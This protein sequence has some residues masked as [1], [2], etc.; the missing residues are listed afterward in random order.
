VGK[1]EHINYPIPPKTHASMYLMHKFWARKP[2]N[3][4]NEYIKI[5]SN[6]GD[7]VLDP[8]CGSGVTAIE[9]VKLERRVVA[10]DIDPLATFITRMTGI[11]IDIEKLKIEF[12]KIENNIKVKI[13]ELYITKCKKCGKKENIIEAIIWNSNK[14]LEIRYSCSCSKSTLWKEP[15]KYDID[16]INRINKIEIPFWYPQN[17]LIWNPRVNVNKGMTVYDLFTHRNLYALSWILNEIENIN[18]KNIKEILKFAFSAS[19]PQ[20]SKLV[21][22]I[23]SK[24]REK[25]VG[26]WSIRGYWIPEEHFEINVWN[27]F[28]E[29]IKKLIRGK[30][31]SN[32]LLENLWF[33]AKIFE[34]LLKDK[35][36]LIQT[37]SARNLEDI[38]D[39]SIDYI[40]TDPPYGDSVPYLELN[41]L[42]SSWL[43]FEPNFEEEIIISDS[44]VRKK[45]S[46]ELYSS[47]LRNSFDVMFRVLK[48]N[49]YL[50]VT[51]HNTDI[52]I[53]NALILAVK[54]AGFE[55][56]KIVYQLPPRSSPKALTAPFG[57]ADG[58]YYIRFY[59]AKVKNKIIYKDIID[60][61]RFENIV[62]QSLIEIIA[63]RMEPVIFTEIL[64][65][66]YIKLDKY[67][68]LPA[69]K[70][71]KLEEIIKKHK[72]KEFI[73]IKN[74]GWW[75]KDPEKYYL[76]ITPL[77]ERIETLIIQLLKR[78]PKIDFDE[79][80]KEIFTKLPNGLS[81]TE[82]K[83]KDI[84]EEYA[85]QS[86]DKSWIRKQSF[87][88]RI[89]EH[90]EMIGY[91]SII[92]KKLGFKILIG[93]RE[94]SS[95]FNDKSL[96]ELNDDVPINIL[97]DIINEIL[98]IDVLWIDDSKIKYSFEVEYSTMITESIIRA[99]YF[100]DYK[101]NKVFVI[102]E[103]R[104]RILYKKINSPALIDKVKEQ[105]WKFMFFKDLR[106]LY[107]MSRTRKGLKIEDFLDSLRQLKSDRNTQINLI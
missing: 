96:Y 44:P 84:L 107:N 92:G 59:K 47:M 83:I 20:A 5:Y 23:H 51:F 50:T 9:A 15:D 106:D 66:I 57:S 89:S 45:R 63:N 72:D 34:D 24:G 40:F 39:N 48:P 87:E 74:E 54:F 93:K 11:I 97:K 26:S 14:P 3:I 79:V 55:L 49:K 16:L 104:E 70:T 56:E 31:E 4:L 13:S 80:L 81:T 94:Q 64:R 99:S 22:Y 32:S 100:K 2:S 36:I 61:I 10:I 19:L 27:C 77:S 86:K 90:S 62:V 58:D 7:I 35:S 53:Y 46:I 103:E 101:V 67:G 37:K 52:N 42:F 18:D 91:L 25:Q 68:C 30:K 88:R 73:F 85:D 105:N 78:K 43:K 33:E 41:Y 28:N 29:R 98:N 95:I 17:E 1:I 38:P 65:D 21:P 76:N 12:E 69:L 102:P 75:L 8:F 82:K 60:E 6:K 71:K